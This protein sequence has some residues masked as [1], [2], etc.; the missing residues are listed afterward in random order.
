MK[1]KIITIILI[2]IMKSGLCQSFL[3]PGVS[4]KIYIP[5]VCDTL[6][7]FN[8][9]S[10]KANLFQSDDRSDFY[11]RSYFS[12]EQLKNVKKNYFF[13][14]SF[15]LSIGFEKE[16]NRG[17]LIPYFGFEY[18]NMVIKGIGKSAHVT[19]LI[20]ISLLN[21]K[22]YELSISGGY[23]YPFFQQEYAGFVT[24]LS[25]VIKLHTCEY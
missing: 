9:M 19:P 4:Y 6:G 11:Y 24:E 14:Y 5:T 17:Y 1:T 23:K 13:C 16:I 10:V 3:N 15:G 20:G 18:G 7:Q 21:M 12:L 2:I 8:G 22:K 25:L